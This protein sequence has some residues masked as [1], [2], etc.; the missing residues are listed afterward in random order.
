M[1]PSNAARKASGLGLARKVKWASAPI[2][3]NSSWCGAAMRRRCWS[4]SPPA[5]S[6]ACSTSYFRTALGRMVKWS[7]PSANPLIS[8]QTA[9]DARSSASNSGNSSKRRF[10]WGTWIRTKT[11][12]SR[13]E[14]STVKLSPNGRGRGIGRRRHVVKQARPP[15]PSG[16]ARLP[17]GSC[18]RSPIGRALRSLC[19]GPPFLGERAVKLLCRHFGS[20]CA[21]VL[22]P[23]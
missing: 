7:P 1:R 5:K 15:G 8:W 4:A 20:P 9:I 14:S 10:G 16:I 21:A 12:R 3:A 19:R 11:A 17:I 23:G 22:A 6:A 2:V 13:A 18:S